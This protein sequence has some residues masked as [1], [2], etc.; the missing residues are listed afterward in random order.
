MQS[1]I[2]MSCFRIISRSWQKIIQDIECVHTHYTYVYKYKSL[3]MMSS[4]IFLSN[5]DM[6]Q[7]D[8]DSS[9][10]AQST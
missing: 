10:R 1:D 8:V 5:C 3:N 4:S 9:L 7:Y 6:T 2:D